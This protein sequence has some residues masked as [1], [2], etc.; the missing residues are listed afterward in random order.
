MTIKDIKKELQEAN[1][2]VF[3][4]NP[5]W[6]EKVQGEKGVY[7]LIRD[8][9]MFAFRIMAEGEPTYLYKWL[10]KQEIKHQNPAAVIL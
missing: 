7:R 4:S 3:S 2:I 10:V 8:D 9:L 1:K 5:L 6:V